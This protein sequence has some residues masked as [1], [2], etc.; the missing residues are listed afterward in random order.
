MRKALLALAACSALAA[1]PASASIDVY[2]AY[3]SG[4]NEVPPADPDGYGVANL[5][6]DNVALTITWSMLVQDI[7]L[8]LSG[9]HI[10]QGVAGTNGGVVVNFSGNLTGSNLFDADLALITPATASGF[11]VNLHNLTYLG[12]AIRGQLEYVGTAAP[13]IAEPGT[14]ALM[15]AGAAAGGMLLRRRLRRR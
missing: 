11:Y 14:A 3:L 7:E 2:V 15:L 5:A 10:H 1:A 12:G 4:A 9:A 13:P 6:I 8:P